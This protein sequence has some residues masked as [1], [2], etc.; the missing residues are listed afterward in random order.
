MRPII[1]SISP[2]TQYRSLGGKAVI[3]CEF[4][5]IPFANVS[6][7]FEAGNGVIYRY[8]KFSNS[9]VL[10]LGKLRRRDTGYYTCVA[11]NRAG[12]V[13]KRAYVKVM[14]EYRQVVSYR[15]SYRLSVLRNVS[16]SR[17]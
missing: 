14:C 13:E 4:G 16:S 11:Y 6:W 17:R 8:T 9:S 10:K 7:K 5:G 12:Q 15:L 2:A 3:E 1:T